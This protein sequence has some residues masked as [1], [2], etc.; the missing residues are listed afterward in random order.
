MRLGTVEHKK[1][2]KV[3]VLVEN[4][5][6]LDVAKAAAQASI[7]DFDFT[8]MQRLIEQGENALEKVSFLLD[9]NN[10]SC[11]I[12]ADEV[13]F[14]PPVIPLQ[15]RAFS[16]F[17]D[18]L[19]NAFAQA[20]KLSGIKYEIPPVWYEQ[21]IYYKGNRLSFV[22]HKAEIKWPSFSE[23]LDIELE[24]A[25]IIGKKGRDIKEEDASNY[26]FGYSILNDIS[27]RDAQMK[28]MPGQMG[29][30]KS[31][32]FDTGNVLGPFILTADE[33]DHP[34]ALNMEARVNGSVWGGGNSKDMHHSFSDIIAHISRS[35]TI[36]PGEVIG[37]GTVGTGSGIESGKKLAPGDEFELEIEKIGTL[38]NKIVRTGL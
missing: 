27:A 23:F 15:Y 19:K 33:V 36:Y 14:R 32:D 2:T 21:P 5:T 11:F 20:T 16:I 22:G 38:S 37:S 7:T 18:H 1:E 24:I 17:E 8:D 29:P 10:E 3:I 26:I 13:V 6:F 4:D 30:A 35:E 25:A 28:E 34:V 9:Q 31:K 12:S